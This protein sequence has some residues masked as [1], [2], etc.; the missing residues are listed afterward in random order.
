MHGYGIMQEVAR[1]SEGAYKLGPG[2]LYDNLQRLMDQG[3]VQEVSSD[4]PRRRNYRSEFAGP[5]SIV[6]GD[7]APGRCGAGGAAALAKIIM[8]RRVYILLLRLHPRAFR[9]RFGDEMLG[10]FDECAG[11]GSLLADG[12][13]SLFRQ[14]T[15][16][17][18]SDRIFS[19]CD[20]GWCTSCFIRRGRRFRA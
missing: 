5:Q 18:Q 3:M 10:I 14:W 15:L 12:F 6:G 7:I 8:T 16:R 17:R 4:D 19:D 11:K 9:Q 1:Q 20:G 13:L 2:T